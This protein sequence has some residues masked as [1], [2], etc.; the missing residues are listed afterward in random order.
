MYNQDDI[1]IDGKHMKN[2]GPGGTPIYKMLS[3]NN[4]IFVML[5]WLFVLK[6]KL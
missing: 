3:L 1:I 6:G 4:L 5:S 2:L